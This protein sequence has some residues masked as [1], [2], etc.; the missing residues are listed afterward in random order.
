[1]PLSKKYDSARF[2][3]I[4][5]GVEHA[6]TNPVADGNTRLKVSYN[7]RLMDDHR[8]IKKYERYVLE[9]LLEVSVDPSST[10]FRPQVVARDQYGSADLWW[11]VLW[12]GGWTSKIEFIPPASGKIKI[13]DPRLLGTFMRLLKS[14]EAEVA[15]SKESPFEA[16][17]M[18]LVQIVL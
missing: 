17:D 15:A 4:P 12:S 11:L 13:F 3:D 6:A 14:T 8:L 9:N 16:R 7:G 1:M 2:A 10:K 5:S 18:T